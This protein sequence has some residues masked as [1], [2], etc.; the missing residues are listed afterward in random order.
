MS[1]KELRE[2]FRHCG[3]SDAD[4][5]IYALHASGKAVEIVRG[6]VKFW[7]AL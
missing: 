4:S 1:D 3:V 7:R 6:G 5:A 2:F